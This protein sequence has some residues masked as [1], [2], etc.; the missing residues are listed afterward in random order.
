MVKAKVIKFDEHDE[1]GVSWLRDWFGVR[2]VKGQGHV[3]R[4]CM[5]LCALVVSML[6]RYS[7][8][9]ATT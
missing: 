5:S 7:L 9:G 6:C 4:K 3:A 2:K 8:D 1:V